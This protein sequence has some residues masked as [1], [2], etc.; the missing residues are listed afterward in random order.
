MNSVIVTVVPPEERATA[1]ALSILAIHLFGDVPSPP[2]IGRISD[3]SSLERAVL[4]VPVAAL[5]AA[6]IWTLE[7]WLGERRERPPE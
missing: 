3:V 7:A 6:A 1:V 4:F 2:L 5:P